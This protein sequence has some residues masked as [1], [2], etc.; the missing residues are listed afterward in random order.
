[1]FEV[2]MCCGQAQQASWTADRDCTLKAVY[3]TGGPAVLSDD[4]TLDENFFQFSGAF[5]QEKFILSIGSMDASTYG[6]LD[7]P[8]AKGK[9]LYLT[10]TSADATAV[11]ILDEPPPIGT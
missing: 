11:L 9:T 8:L 4:P 3:P 2:F 10:A 1:M 6:L 5:V 7:F